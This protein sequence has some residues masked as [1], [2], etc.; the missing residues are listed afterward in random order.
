[1]SEENSIDYGQIEAGY[2]FPP[3]D[4]T[5]DSSAVSIFLEAVEDASL[6]YQDTGLVPPMAVAASAMATLSRTISLPPGSIHVSQELDFIEMVSVNDSLTN[7]ARVSRTQRRGKIHL[8]TVDLDVRNQHQKTVL[9]GKT[10][11][12]LLRKDDDG[13]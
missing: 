12:I 5:L 1:M 10:S 11:F 2:E 13:Q 7:Y 4:Y 9:T 3:G 8:L 6:L